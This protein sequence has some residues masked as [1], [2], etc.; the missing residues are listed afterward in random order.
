MFA[1]YFAQSLNLAS[2][3][4]KSSKDNKTTITERQIFN[5]YNLI[6]TV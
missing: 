1:K 3:Q 5:G 6:V 2:V 4:E